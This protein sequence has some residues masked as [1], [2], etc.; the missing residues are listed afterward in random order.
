MDFGIEKSGIIFDIKKFAIHDG[1]G[2]RTTIFLKGC[3]LNCWWCHNP[4]SQNFNPEKYSISKLDQ[5][6]SENEDFIGK[7]MSVIDI[8]KEIEKDLLFYDESGGGVTFS[9]GEPLGQPEFLLEL[10]KICK[11]NEINTILDTTGHTDSKILDKIKPYVDLFLYDLKFVDNE[12]HEK[13][14]GVSNYQ[15]I[16][17][18]TRLSKEGSNIIIRI[19]I[20]PGINDDEDEISKMNIFISGLTN[21]QR[22]DLLPFHKIGKDKYQK[23]N[24]VY[25][26]ENTD[27][28]SEDLMEK[29]KIKF[30]STG[31]PVKIGG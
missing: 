20:I 7:K 11:K 10:L 2:I 12:K 6:K 25:R 8:F 9:G 22:I 18:L 29:I 21:I 24:M 5:H 17:N 19:P 23:L 27:E 1:P 15:I 4:E 16:N 30:E 13:Y 28:P 26:M 14:T 31:I 3:P